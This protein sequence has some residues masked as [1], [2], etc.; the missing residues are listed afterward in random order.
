MK[1]NY[2]HDDDDDNDEQFYSRNVP[3]ILR[4]VISIEAR[5]IH[6]ASD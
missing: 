1:I 3:D 5:Q 6:V 2:D 4:V